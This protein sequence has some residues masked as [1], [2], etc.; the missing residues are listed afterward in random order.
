MLSRSVDEKK[1]K[2]ILQ[3]WTKTFEI[4]FCFIFRKKLKM[5]FNIIPFQCDQYGEIFATKA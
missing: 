3:I 2:S 1:R 4:C 5:I